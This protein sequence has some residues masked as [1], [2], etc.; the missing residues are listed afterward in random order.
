M[1]E[2]QLGQKLSEEDE[3]KIVAFLQSLTGQ[4]PEVTYPVLPP[5][6]A[7]TPRPTG[8]VK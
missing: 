3:G 8:E 2:A 1:G 5:E 6:T 7:D 4:A